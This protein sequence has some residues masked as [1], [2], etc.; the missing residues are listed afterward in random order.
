MRVRLIERLAALPLAR[1][2][3]KDFEIKMAVQVS[4]KETG[5]AAFG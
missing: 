5:E 3:V 1:F 2:S 4:S